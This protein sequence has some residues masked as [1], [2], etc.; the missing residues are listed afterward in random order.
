[1][2][3]IGGAAGTA[4]TVKPPYPVG[5]LKP[6][7][8][9]AQRQKIYD[10]L[11]LKGYTQLQIVDYII[12]TTGHLSPDKTWDATLLDIYDTV[13]NGG[14]FGKDKTKTQYPGIPGVTSV[15][16]FLTSDALW[17]RVGEIA[18][19]LILITVGFS[20]AFPTATRAIGPGKF[21]KGT[22]GVKYAKLK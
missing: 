21:T 12:S 19:G 6:P 16:D 7:L 13:V 4:G 17:V 14:G 15:L 1:M 22:R 18:A 3:N 20:K 8:T 10:Y 9:S 11:H 2:A 5:Q